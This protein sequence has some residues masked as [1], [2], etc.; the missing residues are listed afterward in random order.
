MTAMKNI[1]F[2]LTTFLVLISSQLKSQSLFQDH[3]QTFLYADFGIGNGGGNLRIEIIDDHLKLELVCSFSNTTLNVGDIVYLNTSPQLPDYNFGNLVSDYNIEIKNGFL[4]ITNPSSYDFVTSFNKIFHLDLDDYCLNYVEYLETNQT[5][6]NGIFALPNLVEKNVQYYDGLGRPTQFI[7]VEAGPQGS[8]NDIISFKGYNS[9]WG[10]LDKEYLPYE[11]DRTENGGYHS[12][13]TSEQ[14]SY[15]D[16]VYGADE[17]HYAFTE[18]D[19]EYSALNRIVAQTGP[20]KA[21]RENGAK[22]IEYEYNTNT[23]SSSEVKKFTILANGN[24]SYVGGYSSGELSR[25]IELDENVGANRGE[26]IEYKDLNGNIIVKKR[27]LESG[28]Y[29]STYFLYDAKSR[30]KYVIQPEAFDIINIPNSWALLNDQQFRNKW[31]FEYTYDNYDRLI[32]KKVPAKEIEYF[33]YDTYD[34]VAMYQDGNLRANNQWKIYAYDKLS[35]SIIEGRVLTTY[36]RSFHQSNLENGIANSSNELYEVRSNTFS[37]GY[38]KDS[39]QLKFGGLIFDKLTYYDDYDVD[40]NGFADYTYQ[41]DIES[42]INDLSSYKPNAHGLKTVVVNKEIGNSNMQRIEVF[43]YNKFNN[44]IQKQ[45]YFNGQSDQN[46]HD[47]TF[48]RYNFR[49]KKTREKHIHKYGVF[50]QQIIVDKKFYYDDRLRLTEIRSRVNTDPEIILAK[51]KYDVQGNVIEKK[52][53]G[54]ISTNTF[55]QDIDYTYNV[56]GWLKTINDIDY[57]IDNSEDPDDPQTR[58][59]GLPNTSEKTSGEEECQGDLFAMHFTYTASNTGNLASHAQ[60]NG[61]IAQIKWQSISDMVPRAYGYNYSENSRL[62]SANYAAFTNTSNNWNQDVGL[63]S[64]PSISY[65]HNGN[66]LALSRNG[67]ADAPIQSSNMID[68]LAYV[69][70]GNQL[71]NVRDNI[72]DLGVNDFK[73]HG[74]TN[75]GAIEYDYDANGNLKNDY[76]RQLNYSYNHLNLPNQIQ[77]GQYAS[78]NLRYGANGSKW[79]KSF[80]GEGDGWFVSDKTD[81]FNSFQY[82]ND[83]L[84]FIHHQ[85]GR[86]VKT[87]TEPTFRYEYYYRDHLG[88]VRLTFSDLN[89]NG[90]INP[91]EVLQENHYYPFGLE[92][93]Q[94]NIAQ[95]GPENQYKYNGKEY[96]PEAIDLD[97]DGKNDSYLNQFDY[98]A[99]YYDPAIARFTAVDPKNEVYNEWAPYLY[100]ANNPLRYEDKNGEGP[101]DKVMGFTVAMVDNMIGG[102][103]PLRQMA[104]NYVSSGGASDFNLGQDMGDVASIVIGAMMIEGGT[105]AATGGT[106]V[107]VTSGGT[108]SP[109]AVPVAL[110][111]A[112]AAAE[113]TIMTV[114]GA[115]NLTSQK[116]RMNTEGK[117]SDYENT[118]KGRSINNR[119][120]N[121]N[122]KEFGENLENAGYKKAQSQDKKVTNYTKDKKKYT[123]RDN[124]K[125]TKGPT[126]DVF[127][128]NVPK[129]KIR[130]KKDD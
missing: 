99:R 118:T 80:E 119:E 13:Y 124:A 10:F 30:L 128:D 76:A 71:I 1:I 18:T 6:G 8:G 92:I 109:V 35:R 49:E 64:V 105:G 66:I 116:D 61:N 54:D 72:A 16:Q 12:D 93:T 32:S 31:F 40:G 57:Q 58:L 127:Q 39:Y 110:A 86:I 25:F 48:F 45:E 56:R 34:R 47:I 100:A 20:G 107:A 91:S 53:H 125:S 63:F 74:M 23:S 33:V 60:Y 41:P 21:W 81:Y 104:Q 24:I 97:N 3:Y 52:L 38:S 7:Q 84:D 19:F 83:E 85:E 4:H 95:N 90:C 26:V 44:V 67:I 73:D 65:D 121:V 11:A 22:L 17:G 126:A 50:L 42:Q 79:Q 111:G 29:S 15:F 46:F 96:Q 37:H 89:N 9:S 120:T 88:N 55:L 117:S 98:G 62:T 27:K 122:K 28:V 87:N 77:F 82:L 5:I 108:A 69:Y 43:L 101:G 78:M 94:L 36:N 59:A 14:N 75:P 70:S 68:D 112:A 106:A 115:N 102:G 2:L 130:L 114:S 123:I 51:L 103:S 129:T 113:G